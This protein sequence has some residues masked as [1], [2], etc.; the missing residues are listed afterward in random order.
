MKKLYLY[1]LAALLLW[2]GSAG[3]AQTAAGGQAGTGPGESRE[4][5]AERIGAYAEY[6]RDQWRI[7][8]MAVAFMQ[9]GELILAKGFGTKETGRQDPVDART[10]FQ[11]GSVSKSF[12]A[13]VMASLVD[14]GKV[15]WDDT[16]KNILPDFEMYD[17]WVTENMQVKDI[18][19]HRSGL[20]EQAGTYIPNLGYGR[21]DIYRMLPL[22]KPVYGFR[23]DFQYNNITFIIASRIIEKVTGKSWEENVQERVF[24]PVGM[25]ASSV[26]G[27]GF[28]AATNVA[29]PHEYEFR[30]G[31]ETNPLYGEEQAL[32]WLTVI[33]PAGS[34]NASAI[35]L[36]KYARFHMENGMTDKGEQAVSEKQMKYL[37]TGQMISSQDTNRTT[38]YGTCWYVEQNDRYRVYFHTG[39]TWGMTALC[40]FVPQIKLAGAIL[41]NCE[42]GASPRYAIMRRLVDLIM[43]APEK[44][45]SKES[46]DEWYARNE[47]NWNAR[48]PETGA[49]APVPQLSA[50]TGTYTKAEPFGDAQITLENGDLYIAVGKCG[51]RNKLRHVNG[52]RFIFNSDGHGFP[53]NFTLDGKGAAE[54]FEIEFGYGEEKDFGPW[55]KK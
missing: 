51:F 20:R 37:H 2:S 4:I 7:P 47:K 35:D 21:E 43:N 23:G 27:P 38:L 19:I 31:I 1:S 12:T 10:V 25:S 52:S 53:V 18:M 8:G 5:L 17:P 45:Y 44:D 42:A 11:V 24:D 9:D 26:N 39:T 16:V 49:E 33:G 13:T 50:L 48:K 40:F 22:M 54:S 30:G 32:H 14:E 41:V 28:A 55:K 46:F 15:K 34:V 36:V 3:Y 6:V 29:V